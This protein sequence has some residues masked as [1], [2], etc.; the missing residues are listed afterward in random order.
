MLERLRP[1][2]DDGLTMVETVVA[3]LVFGLF[4]AFAARLM[5]T[6]TDVT[7]GNAQRLV[8]GNLAAQHVE[9]LRGTGALNLPDGRSVAPEQPVVGGTTY[10][11]TRRV[12]FVAS[13]GGASVCAGSADTLA[14]KMVT[15]EV[16]WPRMG[17]TRPVRSDT[18]RTVGIGKTAAD[19]KK[20]TL[21]VEV[22]KADGTPHSGVTVTVTPGPLTAVTGADGCV[23]FPNLATTSTY[24]AALNAFPFV[25]R[26]G[27]QSTSRT[28]LSLTAGKVTKVQ[29]SYARRGAIAATPVAPAGYPAPADLVVSLDASILT[30]TTT[31][32]FYDCAAVSTSPQNCVT[33][34]PRTAAALFPADYRVW[35]GA[36]AMPSGLPGVTVTSDATA[37]T[38]VALGGLQVLIAS[39]GD[40]LLSST[41]YA[42]RK[43]T[44]GCT[45][46]ASYVMSTLS[47]GERRIALPPGSWDIVTTADGT[48]TT[49]IPTQTV[50]AGAVTT[51]T[52]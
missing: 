19:V 10:T 4:A 52:K 33:G 12:R 36:C 28:G 9:Q 15:V 5:V 17:R 16:T 24:T 44:T 30:P 34:T 37:S 47:A 29:M 46:T 14:Y 26:Q 31:R 20:G 25:N 42:F 41:L 2:E 21:A 27:A 7:R 32:V 3:M 51:V 13:Q 40:P 50:T 23:V 49:T 35:P 22:L 11:L 8:A 39:S 45:G 1:H 43:T 18:L 48:G 38:T 6:V